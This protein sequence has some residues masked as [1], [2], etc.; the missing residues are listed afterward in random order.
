[1]TDS[2]RLRYVIPAGVFRNEEEIERSRFIATLAH[3]GTAPAAKSF[4][5]RIRTEFP[6]AS[7]NCWA[8]LIGPPGTTGTVGMSDDG[9]P[10]GTAGRPMLTTLQHSGMGDVAVV[11]TRYFGGRKLG[12]GGLVRAYSGAVKAAIENVELTERVVFRKLQVIIDYATVTAF[13]RLLARYEADV[14]AETFAGKVEYRLRLPAGREKAFRTE[15]VNLTRGEAIVETTA[16][17]V[18]GGVDG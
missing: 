18:K 11:V 2:D 10:R 9:E 16:S 4:V 8:Y 14:D 13:K 17:E 5:D 15:L 7:H 3:T 6:D 1:M 12:R